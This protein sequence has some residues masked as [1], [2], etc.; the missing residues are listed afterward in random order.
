MYGPDQL[1]FLPVIQLLVQTP[2]PSWPCYLLKKF[3]STSQYHTIAKAKCTN[4]L[5]AE[6]TTPSL[7][8]SQRY[9]AKFILL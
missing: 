2:S 8:Y 9:L 6:C 1:L 7:L 3:R 4:P 5:P